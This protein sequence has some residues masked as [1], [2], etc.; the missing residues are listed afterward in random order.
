MECKPVWM[1]LLYIQYNLKQ[2]IEKAL[3]QVV[4]APSPSGVVYEQAHPY[5][6]YLNHHAGP[7][8]ESLGGKLTVGLH[9]LLPLPGN[10]IFRGI[11]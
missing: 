5:A 11:T 3:V 8:L 9:F 6:S 4:R 2:M 7:S 10:I 1:I